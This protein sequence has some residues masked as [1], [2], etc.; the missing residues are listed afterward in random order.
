M[1]PRHPGLQ[2]WQNGHKWGVLLPFMA[3]DR[4]LCSPLATLMHCHKQLHTTAQSQ[5]GLLEYLDTT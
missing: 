2:Q 5:I 4:A 1:L 3:I